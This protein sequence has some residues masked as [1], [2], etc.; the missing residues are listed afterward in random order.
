VSTRTHQGGCPLDTYSGA[1][2]ASVCPPDTYGGARRASGCPPD[3]YGGARRASG[4]PPDT[5]G[6]ARRAS[7]CPP[8]T[9]SGARRASR[10]LPA[11][12]L[13]H[14]PADALLQRR[15][16]ICKHGSSYYSFG[17]FSP[18]AVNMGCILRFNMR[19]PT[20]L[21]TRGRHRR[22]AEYGE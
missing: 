14:E 7:G 2:R 5:Y 16:R 1:R 11:R 3:T 19:R 18:G 22:E 15:S 6:G 12:Q 9:Y 10:R 21:G 8:D 20:D 13:D 17:R 4:C